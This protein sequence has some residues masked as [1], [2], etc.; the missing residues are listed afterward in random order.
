M[1]DDI[2]IVL[3]ECKRI[4]LGTGVNSFEILQTV[5]KSRG[6]FRDMALFYVRYCNTG[7]SQNDFCALITVHCIIQRQVMTF[8]YILQL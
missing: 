1:F 6:N 3:L 7:E 4:M 2:P 8:R 5:G